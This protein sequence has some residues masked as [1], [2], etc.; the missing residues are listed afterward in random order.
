MRVTLD[1]SI[2]CDISNKSFS[3]QYTNDSVESRGGKFVMDTLS[4]VSCSSP[5]GSTVSPG[6]ADIVSFSGFGSW[7]SDKDRHLATVQ[8]STATGAKYFI[9]QIDGGLISN[10][11][12]KLT[13]ETNP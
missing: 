2:S 9:V 7:S 4:A 6:D 1:Y 3:F 13:E 12:T 11:D 10:A 5:L 8:V